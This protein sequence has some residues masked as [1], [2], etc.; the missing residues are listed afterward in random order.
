M[1]GPTGEDEFDWQ[2][3]S[4]VQWDPEKLSGRANVA[5]TRMFADSVLSNFDSGLSEEEIADS[6]GTELAHVQAILSFAHG[7]RL[8]A[9][10]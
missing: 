10:A 3:C 2:G 5:G 1:Y 4:A 7:R 9:I 8:K 6:Y